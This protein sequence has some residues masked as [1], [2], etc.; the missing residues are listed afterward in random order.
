[1]TLEPAP[2]VDLRG[3]GADQKDPLLID[4]A[5]GEVADQLAA[6]VQHRAKGDAA[7]SGY[8]VCHYVGEPLLRRRSRDLELAVIG[9]LQEAHRLVHGRALGCDVW[10]RVGA[11]ES[12]VLGCFLRRGGKPERMLE[13]AVLAEHGMCRLQ[14]LIYR[15][16]A[17]R[18]RGRQLFVREADAEAP[19]VVLAHLGVG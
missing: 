18:A 2:V 10:V 5:H 17:Q 9:Y 19:R 13:T 8:A 16:G 14:A 11:M 4:A 1:M 7:H 6:L 3:P 12:D 15:R